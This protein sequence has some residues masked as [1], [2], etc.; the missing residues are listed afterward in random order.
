[1]RQPQGVSPR[2]ASQ[3]L[4]VHL[5]AAHSSFQALAEQEFAKE[6]DLI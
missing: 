3:H 2:R 5:N 6:F 1:V 4:I